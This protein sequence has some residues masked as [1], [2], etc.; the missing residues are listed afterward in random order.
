MT[1]ADV[2]GTDITINIT[3]DTTASPI[4][5]DEINNRKFTYDLSGLI[6]QDVN[7]PDDALLVY[8]FVKGGQF[9][10][11]FASSR[12]LLGQRINFMLKLIEIQN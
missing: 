4:T 12:V 2:G 8:N 9:V 7:D 10:T 11:K 6:V 1:E 3:F 5:P